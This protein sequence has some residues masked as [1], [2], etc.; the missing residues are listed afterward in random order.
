[1][2][3]NYELVREIVMNIG[4]LTEILALYIAYSLGADRWELGLSLLLV[5]VIVNNLLS[6]GWLWLLRYKDG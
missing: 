1:M 5:C 6:R 3:K 2:I 4:S